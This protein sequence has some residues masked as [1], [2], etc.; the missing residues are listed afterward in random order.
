MWV[1]ADGAMRRLLATCPDILFINAAGN[2]DQSDDILAS[3]PQVIGA[4]NLLVVGATGTS[5]LP[6]SFTTY[7]KGVGIYAW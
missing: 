7:G 5:G 2:S 3:T 4:P 1:K 6:T